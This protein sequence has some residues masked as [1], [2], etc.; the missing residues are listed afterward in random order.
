MTGWDFLNDII[1]I[2]PPVLAVLFFLIVG[3]LFA[4]GFLRHGMNFIRYGFRQIALDSS[5]EKQFGDLGS[6]IDGLHTEIGDFKTELATIKTNH[7]GHLKD[8]LTELT[9]ILVDKNIL[10]NTDKAR[11]DN[12]LRGM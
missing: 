6:R 11:L 4:I 1:R 3:V 10:N 12:H 7:F 5:L 2:T 8:F 9:G